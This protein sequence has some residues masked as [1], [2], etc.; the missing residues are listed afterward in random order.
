MKRLLVT[1]IAISV[2]AP[3]SAQFI[4]GWN[5]GYALAPELNRTIYVYNSLNT[6][7]TKSMN[8]VHW[9][10]GPVGGVRFGDEIF[11]EL[12]YSRKRVLVSSGWDSS[13]VGMERQLKVLAN[14]WNFGFGVQADSWTLGASV[15]VGRFKGRGRRGQTDLI[16]DQEWRELWVLANERFLGI[17]F[18]RFF[19]SF[20]FFAERSFGIMSVRAYAQ[21]FGMRV[22]MDGLDTWLVGSQLN[23]FLGSK[24]RFTNFGLM[25][26]FN[27]G[28]R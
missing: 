13:G 18:D 7:L 5:A 21:A 17:S 10:Q 28:G 25:V 14:S 3:L 20:T 15:D 9:Y 19:P 11:F 2:F 27:F 8:E 1:L 4:V 24:E 12:L 23:W 22:T 16:G 6:T 26:S